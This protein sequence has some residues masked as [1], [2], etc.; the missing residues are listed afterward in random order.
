MR[1]RVKTTTMVAGATVIAMLLGGVVAAK[2]QEQATT[3]PAMG[4]SDALSREEIAALAEAVRPV[5]TIAGSRAVQEALKGT[6]FGFSRISG[7]IAPTEYMPAGADLSLGHVGITSDLG[8]SASIATG[9]AASESESETV[10]FTVPD[11]KTTDLND[12]ALTASQQGGV[13]PLSGTAL[14]AVGNCST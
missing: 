9:L 10:T 14:P 5:T 3:D 6:A 12:G 11:S 2:A 13:L 7:R 4:Q 1:R 8:E